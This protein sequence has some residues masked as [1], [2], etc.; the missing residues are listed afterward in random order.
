MAQQRGCALKAFGVVELDA[1][2]AFVVLPVVDD[3]DV[4]DADAADSQDR[5]DGRDGAGFV[6]SLTNAL[7]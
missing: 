1:Q 2:R 4:F 6:E 7:Q 3:S 5:G